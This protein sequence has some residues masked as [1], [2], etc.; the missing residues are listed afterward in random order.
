MPQRGWKAMTMASAV[1]Y[2]PQLPMESLLVASAPSLA[3]TWPV[4]DLCHQY[5]FILFTKETSSDQH[6]DLVMLLKSTLD[7]ELPGNCN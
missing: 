3:G 2:Y 7:D 1:G 6:K 5:A 4:V